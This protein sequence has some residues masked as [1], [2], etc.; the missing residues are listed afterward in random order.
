M[1]SDS[2]GAYAHVVV[3]R[4]R[5]DDRRHSAVANGLQDR[6]DVVWCIDHDALVVVSD[7]PDVVVDV[8]R[9]AVQRE[10]S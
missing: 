10:R 7:D 6:V 2:S 9:L 1:R 3:V 4:V 8:E 5:A